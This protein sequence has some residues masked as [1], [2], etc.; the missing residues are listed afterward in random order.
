MRSQKNPGSVRRSDSVHQLSQ[1]ITETFII[2]S[3]MEFLESTV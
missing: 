1:I 3:E 2:I